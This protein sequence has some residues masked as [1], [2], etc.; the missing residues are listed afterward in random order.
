MKFG[1]ENRNVNFQRELPERILSTHLPAVCSVL[2]VVA[3]SES[4]LQLDCGLAES[5]T[6]AKN[7]N[8]V[9]RT[10]LSCPLSPPPPAPSPPPQSRLL[11]HCAGGETILRCRLPGCRP[12]Q[13]SCRANSRTQN[14][15][16]TSV[17]QQLPLGHRVCRR[18]RTETSWHLQRTR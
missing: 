2:R 5:P 17:R 15:Q 10:S 9:D 11:Q 18:N 13:V 7:N 12:Q 8:V 4:Y 3:E 6:P 14:I 16:Q 1:V